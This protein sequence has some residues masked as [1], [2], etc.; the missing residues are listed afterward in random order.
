MLRQVFCTVLLMLSFL[1]V[2]AQGYVD[3]AAVQPLIDCQDGD[4]DSVAHASWHIYTYGDNNKNDKKGNY[5]EFLEHI[6][7]LPGGCNDLRRY[8][9]EL[10]NRVTADNFKDGMELL[11]PDSF[12]QDYRAYSPYPFH[13]HAADTLPKL[14]II[15][16]YTQT[17][18][19]YE[20]GKLVRWGVLSSGNTN[21]KTPPGRFNFNWKDEYRLSNAAPPG[22]VWELRFMFNIYSKWGVHIHQ[23]SLPISRPASHGCVRVAMAD[24]LWNYDWANEWVHEKG[25][26]VRNGTPVMVINNNPPGKVMHWLIKGGQV[27]SLVTLPY[28]LMDVPAGAYEQKVADWESGW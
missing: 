17:F 26:L 11:V 15:D 25:K 2:P 16:K 24:A 13:Y 7:L 20:Y 5:T 1:Y 4:I 19:A 18:G 3:Q 21:E 14:F 9:V 23:Y 12:I 8:V 28:D 27:E 6:G 22:E 10:A